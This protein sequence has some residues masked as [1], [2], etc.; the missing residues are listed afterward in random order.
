MSN[1]N[2]KDI[3]NRAYQAVQP[4]VSETLEQLFMRSFSLSMTVSEEDNM[5]VTLAGERYP[6]LRISF[7]SEGDSASAK[8][9]ILMD[10]DLTLK[11]YSWMIGDEPEESVGE[12]QIEGL[13]EAISQ[14]V[15]Q[16]QIKRLKY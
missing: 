5:A 8:N 9:I 14:I 4:I 11:L 12:A 10:T 13:Q 15:S 1:R 2:M 6:A 16:I 7:D 3:F